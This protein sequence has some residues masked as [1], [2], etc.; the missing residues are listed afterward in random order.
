M[1]DKELLRALGEGQVW[2]LEEAIDRY[3]A[4]VGKIL[5][6]F[7]LPPQDREEAAADVFAALW[8]SRSRLREGG[9]LTP[10]LAEI[11]RNTAR[12]R[13]GRRRPEEPLGE[14]RS[15]QAPPDEQVQRREEQ[16]RV[17]Q[18]VAGLPETDREIFLRYYYLDQRVAEI[19]AA[20][21][22]NPSTV[23]SR[24]LRGRRS[25]KKTLEEVL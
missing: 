16:R 23:K 7:H 2:A 17:R 18:A 5:T 21:E 24:L 10:Y 22:M 14:V 1:D 3:G 20:M 15:C 4:Y 13:L 8:R 9:A 25:L 11:T 19:A 6:A 12:K